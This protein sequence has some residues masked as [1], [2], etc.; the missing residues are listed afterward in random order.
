[1]RNYTIVGL[2]GPTGSGKSTVSEIFRE[3]GFEVINADELAR[4]VVSRGSVCL[5]Q[6][7]LAFG[8]DIIDNN[9]DL[10]RRLLAKRAFS[11]NE[12]TAMLNDITHP[13]IFLL[14]LKRCREYIDSGRS[15]I[16]FDAPVL[17]ESNSDLMCDTVVCVVAPKAVRMERLKRRDGISAKQIEE[18]I[19]AQHS[20][21]YYIEKSD[22]V[23]DGSQPLDK[24]RQDVCDIIRSLGGVV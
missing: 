2:T 8:S 3:Q 9:G 14:S 6:L 10:D 7:S 15:K 22:H 23:I 11:S 20:D 16:V 4:E 5:K 18:R 24:V 13:H 17:F 12:N 21:D 1:M 19:N